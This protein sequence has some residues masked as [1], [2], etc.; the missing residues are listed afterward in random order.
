MLPANL[1]KIA[2]PVLSSIILHRESL[3]TQLY[4]M[5]TARR[6]SLEKSAAHYKLLLLCAPA[7]YG[8]TTLL[9]D[10]AHST[11]IPCCWYFLDQQDADRYTFLQTLL[12]SIQH[13]FPSFGTG[14]DLL[15]VGKAS[16]AGPED[17]SR[18]FEAFLDALIDALDTEITQ[19]FAIVLSN[20]HEVDASQSI[21]NL[22]NYFLQKAP[23][24][25]VLIIESRS[26]PSIEFASLLAHS[27]AVGWGSNRLRM[28]AQEILALAQVQGVSPISEEEAEQLAAAFDGW[29]AGIL[30]G[31]RLGDAEL[32]HASTRTGLLKGLPSMR[33]ERQKLFAYLVN[34]IFKH[35][36]AAYAFLKEAAILQQMVPSMCDA[37]LNSENSSEHLSC[38]ARQGMF[39]TCNDNG[40][41]LIYTCHPV[42][43]ELLYD[44]LRTRSPD[45]FAALH[46]KAAELFEAA[47]DYDMAISHMLAA[48]ENTLA[49]RLI[50]LAHE[51]MAAREHTETLLRWIE[52][53]PA[54][55]IEDSPELLLILVSIHLTQGEHAQALTLLD[56]ASTI[57]DTNPQAIA[58][59]N[60]LPSWQA[61]ATILRSKALF[62]IGKYKEA[63]QL[64]RQ[65]LET[66]AMDEVKMR[67]DAHTRFGICAN[68]L[69]DLSSGI[70]HLQ[71]ALQLYGRNIVRPQ[72]ADAHSALASAYNLLGNFALAEHHISRAINCCEQ[73]HDERGK[74]NNLTRMGVY[75]QRQGMF[76]EAEAVLR[77]AATSISSPGFEREHAYILVNLGSVY[78]DQQHYEQSLKT[79]EEGLDLA[80]Q[81]QDNYLINCS[82]C[83]LALTY[84]FMGDATTAML[85]ISETNLPPLNSSSIGYEQAIYGLTHATILLHQQRYDD[86]HHQLTT[87]AASL[88]TV[89]LK[90]ELLRVKLCLAACHLARSEQEEALDL[91][92]ELTTLLEGQDSYEQLILVGLTGFS[93]LHQL[94]KTHPALER[95]RV[96]LHFKSATQNSKKDATQTSA[97]ATPALATS[98]RMK[99]KVQAFGEPTVFLDEQPI[100]HWRMARAMELFFFL[101]DCGRP[102]RKEQII[103]A[104][105]SEADEQ[106]NQTFHST[107]Y[108]LRKALKESCVVSHRGAYSLDFSSLHGNNAQYDVALFKEYY[109]QAKQFLANENDS[110][111]KTALLA[112]VD[113]YQGDY[114]QPFYS[115]WCTF[116]RDELRRTYLEA[117]NHLA[118]IFWRLEMFDESAVH[119]QHMLAMDSWIEEAHYGLMRYY[120]RTGKRGLA[121]RQYQRC[122]EILAQELGAEPGPAIQGLYHRIISASTQE[123]TKK[124]RRIT[125]ISQELSPGR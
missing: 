30:L 2:A 59:P 118:H 44:E 63:Q 21:T 27:Q 93:D 34:E 125:A 12:A 73:L 97:T 5:V 76:V 38:L 109:A 58:D 29:V 6:F 43:R 96:L 40:P 64:C 9:A 74:V 70:E 45:R 117:R 20:Y 65:V 51:R 84:L 92:E 62:Q 122:A 28:S 87:L 123:P 81:L 36:S 4:D 79:L 11:Q 91:L 110:E 14:L 77:Q 16:S 89:G 52:A 68:L 22:M 35:Q 57:L 15:L 120:M 42:L 26:T 88:K 41:Y 106:I 72:V 13:C 75:K 90:R 115:D 61:E 33:V 56:T 37:L 114:V 19:R 113:L 116:R 50:I 46:R 82:L 69:G 111:A 99:L 104:L 71:K 60:D 124:I 80:R 23:S 53:L 119:W 105:W 18:Y 112:M 54:K 17:D 47:H 39:V 121:L 3:V 10:F 83:Y 25:C 94:V 55:I 67:A 7:G 101:L 49:A 85:L 100:T 8:K 24:Q 31:T 1:S 107:I 66:T 78:Q 95:L 98:N 102:M 108:Y 86:A 103:T 48:G 32:L